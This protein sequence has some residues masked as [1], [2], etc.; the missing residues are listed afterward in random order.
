MLFAAAAAD[1]GLRTLIAADKDVNRNHNVA[2][3]TIAASRRAVCSPGGGERDPEVFQGEDGWDEGEGEG[4]GCWVTYGWRRRSPWA[5]TRTRTA[6]GRVV[7]LRESAPRR[8]R[9]VARRMDGRLILDLVDSSPVPPRPRQRLAHPSIVQEPDNVPNTDDAE[10]S[11]AEE[12]ETASGADIMNPRGLDVPATVRAKIVASS[13]PV[14]SA[15]PVPA[16]GCFEAVIRTSPL[17]KV[18]VSMPRMVH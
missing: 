1:L 8:G 3:R 17:R 9:I 15:S 2:T 4:R 13:S 12:E 11:D 14:G 6:D 16:M 18:P 10:A 7:V 5:L